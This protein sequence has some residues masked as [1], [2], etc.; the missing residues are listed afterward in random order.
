VNA[1][2]VGTA[3]KLP[4]GDGGAEFRAVSL[5]TF[6]SEWSKNLTALATDLKHMSK[7]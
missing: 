1:I 2:L 4:K 3:E 7:R 5:D 6:A